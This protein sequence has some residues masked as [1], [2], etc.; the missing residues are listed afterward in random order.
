MRK[1]GR[2]RSRPHSHRRVVPTGVGSLTP[3]FVH[4][5]AVKTARYVARRSHRCRFRRRTDEARKFRPCRPAVPRPVFRPGS[6]TGSAMRGIASPSEPA[7]KSGL[8]TAH[9]RGFNGL[10]VA[11]APKG[12]HGFI[13]RPRGLSPS[14]RKRFQNLYRLSGFPR[15]S[16]EPIAT[17]D[18]WRVRPV[19]ESGKRRKPWFSTFNPFAGGQGWITL[20][21]EPKTAGYPRSRFA[22]K[23]SRRAFSLMKPAASFWS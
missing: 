22:S 19:F 21:L 13:P 12:D 1:W 9:L 14:R 17:L 4:A 11:T 10:Q 16:E 3:G 8:P 7:G 5:P 2:P 15:R 23:R 20:V 18:V 6:S